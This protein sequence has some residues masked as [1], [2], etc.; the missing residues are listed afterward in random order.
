MNDD[1]SDVSNNRST[2]WT[3][4]LEYHKQ[5][6]A[7]TACNNNHTSVPLRRL[8]RLHI[9][10]TIKKSIK[11]QILLKTHISSCQR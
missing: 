4:I 9:N 6:C 11:K 7:P 8:R 5:Y 10:D 1:V 2:N 3:Y